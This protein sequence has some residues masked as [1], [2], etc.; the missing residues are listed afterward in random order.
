MK[1]PATFWNI[2]HAIFECWAFKRVRLSCRHPRLAFVAICL[3]GILFVVFTF[4]PPQ[5]S[6]FRDPLSENYGIGN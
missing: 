4:A 5:I 3:I 2:S 1:K 6:L